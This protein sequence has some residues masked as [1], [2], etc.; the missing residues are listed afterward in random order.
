VPVEKDYT[1]D[2][3]DGEASLRELFCGRSQLLVHHFMFAPSWDEGCPSCSSVADGYH[4]FRVH[5]DHHDVAMATVSRAP[6]AK[7]IA[8]GQRM[9]WTFP[10]ASSSRNDFTFDFGVSFTERQ[11]AAGAEH[12]FQSLASHSAVAWKVK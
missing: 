9:A 10:W 6:I 7:L 5:L 12:N 3:E 1:F 2:L 4:G 11:L 8:Y